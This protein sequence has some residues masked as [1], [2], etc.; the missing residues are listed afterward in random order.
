MF[1]LYLLL[2]LDI[3]ICMQVTLKG[4]WVKQ[5]P[6]MKATSSFPS[7]VPTSLSSF[8]PFFGLCFC[9]SCDGSGHLVFF[10]F[11]CICCIW[12]LFNKCC[13]TSKRVT[14]QEGKAKIGLF[15]VVFFPFVSRMLQVVWESLT[16]LKVCDSWKLWY[17][18]SLGG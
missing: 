16:T 5:I 13:E 8:W 1:I 7:L 9:H 15:L 11:F 14:R 10:A 18:I 4:L 6:T 17:K 3:T 2:L 12:L